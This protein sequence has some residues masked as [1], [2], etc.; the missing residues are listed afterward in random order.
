[1]TDIY[2]QIMTQNR[3]EDALLSSYKPEYRV[4]AQISELWCKNHTTIWLYIL[5]GR[6][7]RQNV[8]EPV[9]GESQDPFIVRASNVSFVEQMYSSFVD[10]WREIRVMIR[11]WWGGGWQ[12]H[13]ISGAERASSRQTETAAG[14]HDGLLLDRNNLCSALGGSKPAISTG[15]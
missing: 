11:T 14:T 10:F 6:L 9:L 8:D 3:G 5:R 13:F 1:M 12:K 2:K 4:K 15:R 7:E